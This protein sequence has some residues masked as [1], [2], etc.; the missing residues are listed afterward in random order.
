MK[1]ALLVPSLFLSI[2]IH[3]QKSPDEI[4][5]KDFRPQSIYNVP[6]NKVH[7]AE[8]KAHGIEN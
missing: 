2:Y 8:S 4:L 3:A 6:V 7:R 1:I 5:L